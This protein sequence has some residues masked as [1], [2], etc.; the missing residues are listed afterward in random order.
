[1]AE[2]D[3]V[4]I[5]RDD[6][7]CSLRLL[8]SPDGPRGIAYPPRLDEQPCSNEVRTIH[9]RA[10]DHAFLAPRFRPPHAVWEQDGLLVM[11]MLKPMILTDT[12]W[13]LRVMDRL[14][15]E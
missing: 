5:R 4:F 9:R 14:L 2:V 6:P 3:Y 10:G 7:G 1:P 13:F 15:A 8:V 12:D 11:L